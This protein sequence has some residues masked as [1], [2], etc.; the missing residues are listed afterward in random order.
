LREF[1]GEHFSVPANAMRPGPIAESFSSVETS[2]TLG[3][4]RGT[5]VCRMLRWGGLPAL[6]QLVKAL[7]ELASNANRLVGIISDPATAMKKRFGAN[8]KRIV[9]LT[10]GNSRAPHARLGDPTLLRLFVGLPCGRVRRTPT[11][12]T[13]P[14]ANCRSARSNV[15]GNAE[16]EANGAAGGAKFQCRMTRDSVRLVPVLCRGIL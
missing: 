13:L 7:R 10:D 3:S 2:H 16:E 8:I 15:I 9:A 11:P 12:M 5:F 6:L 4:R 14:R 1:A